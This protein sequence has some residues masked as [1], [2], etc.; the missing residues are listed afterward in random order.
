MSISLLNKS[1]PLWRFGKDK[2]AHSITRVFHHTPGE[3]EE[4]VR[5]HPSLI[6][7]GFN[8]GQ[9]VK[10]TNKETGAFTL[11]Y[12]SG[13]G[14]NYKLW[15][16]TIALSYDARQRLGVNDSAR[17]YDLEI[18]KATFW[19]QEYFYLFQQADIGARRSH[20]YS[21]Q[22][23]IMGCIGLILGVISFL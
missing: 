21:I 13:A 4:V 11:A 6:S 9:L 7:E 1:L 18:Q 3:T 14:K 22:S 15:K 17:E 10:I 2:H 23:Y 12:A 20:H 5:V 19:E 8:R 16:S